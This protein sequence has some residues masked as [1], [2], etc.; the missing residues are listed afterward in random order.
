MKASVLQAAQEP[1]LPG[2]ATAPGRAGTCAA[3]LLTCRRALRPR[4]AW[5]TPAFRL[6]SMWGGA[7]SAPQGCCQVEAVCLWAVAWTGPC[8][9]AGFLAS[10]I[11]PLCPKPVCGVEPRGRGPETLVSFCP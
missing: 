6:T 5:L 11:F 10:F 3:C 1:G 4:E 7:L 8:Q 2:R 9:P